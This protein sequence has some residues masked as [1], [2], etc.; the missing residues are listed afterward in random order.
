MHDDLTS[1]T[2]KTVQFYDDNAISKKFNS[3]TETSGKNFFKDVE[4]V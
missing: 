1:K 4:L 2:N 3:N